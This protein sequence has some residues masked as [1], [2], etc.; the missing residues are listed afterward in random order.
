[1]N[2][3][4]SWGNAP[5]TEESGKAGAMPQ[6]RKRAEK[7]GQC[8]RNV[9]GQKSWGN[10]PEKEKRQMIGSEEEYAPVVCRFSVFQNI[11]I[12]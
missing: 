1:V 3:Q 9:K 4:K 12:R 7:L 10:A 5:E 6:K 11:Y 8:P 2:G